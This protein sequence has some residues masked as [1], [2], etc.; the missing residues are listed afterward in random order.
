M[1]RWR[2]V[3]LNG[4]IGSH[5]VAEI[6]EGGLLVC[7]LRVVRA[8]FRS[9]APSRALEPRRVWDVSIRV[10]GRTRIDVPG[11]AHATLRDAKAHAESELARI[12][13]AQVSR[14]GRA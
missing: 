2:K 10:D 7:E 9:A 4:D 12:R 5:H 1:I 13:G 3:G 8:H 14:S 6:R 11:G